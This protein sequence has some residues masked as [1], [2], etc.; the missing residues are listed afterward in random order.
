MAIFISYRRQ[1]TAGY[2]GRLYDRLAPQ[3]GDDQVFMDVTDLSLGQDFVDAINQ[4]LDSCTALIVLIG[5]RWLTARDDNDRVRVEDPADFVRIEV[6][7]ALRR[8]ILVVPVL[9]GG[10]KMPKAQLLPAD[11]QLLVRR[12][13][14]E[15]SHER[16]A[17][18][19][20][21]LAEAL[22]GSLGLD[23]PAASHSSARVASPTA[24][25]NALGPVPSDPRPR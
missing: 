2:A 18:D 4:K 6:G 8:G 24:T 14:L 20:D 25:G 19:A 7:A 16:F 12:N 9:V 23:A 11:L 17:F 5:D 3:F 21:R 15:L 22:S 1:D 13:A 10:A